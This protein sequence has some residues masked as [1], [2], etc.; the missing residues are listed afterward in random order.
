MT[1]SKRRA[2]DMLPKTLKRTVIDRPIVRL[3]V[4]ASALEEFRLSECGRW[5]DHGC[6]YDRPDNKPLAYNLLGR[7][8]TLIALVDQAEVNEVWWALCAGSFQVHRP[9]AATALA[10][11][12]RPYVSDKALLAEWPHPKGE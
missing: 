6:P 7:F 11:R 9:R 8:K 2:R 3:S 4:N 12:L 1:G 5:E 10:K